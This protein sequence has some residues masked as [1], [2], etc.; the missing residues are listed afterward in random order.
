[1]FF[2][3]EFTSKFFFKNNIDIQLGGNNIVLSKNFNEQI[4]GVNL[5]KKNIDFKQ[6]N[7]CNMFIYFNLVLLQS[8]EFY[9]IF[10]YCCINNTH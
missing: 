2:K 1:M 5:L 8:L 7:D 10:I 4:D 9:K 3:K 6:L